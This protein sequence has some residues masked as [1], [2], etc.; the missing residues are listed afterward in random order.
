MSVGK[1]FKFTFQTS[2]PSPI[3]RTQRCCHGIRTFVILDRLFVSAQNVAFGLWLWCSITY[4]EY[5]PCSHGNPEISFRFTFY[6]VGWRQ[7][8]P[9]IVRLRS[10]DRYGLLDPQRIITII[11]SRFWLAA[12]SSGSFVAHYWSKRSHLCLPAYVSVNSNC[13]HPPPGKP[14]GIW[15]FGKFWVKCPA[16]VFTLF[17]HV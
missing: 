14:P 8:K 13:R 9:P 1:G 11:Y 3:M 5:L 2:I 4:R 17:R 12:S 15:L 16:I 6:D 10:S 7:L